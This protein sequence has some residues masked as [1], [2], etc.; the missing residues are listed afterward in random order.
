[1][2]QNLTATHA[3]EVHAHADVHAEENSTENRKFAM[4]LFLGSEVMFFTVLIAGVIYA[5]LTHGDEHSVLNIPLTSLNTFLL[6]TSSFTV[7]RSIAAI[8]QADRTKFLR[9]I[10]LTTI[11]G[12]IFL[13]IQVVEFSNLSK[14]GM[15]LSG[16]A[17][18]PRSIFGMAFF[19]L[20][21]FHGA[22]V[23]VGVIWSIR[24]FINAFNG[25]FTQTDHFPV[26]FFGLYWHF[27]DVVWIIIF[28]VVYLI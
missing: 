19:T 21:G 3:A 8:Q 16:A 28:T 17:N 13:A 9:S 7:V 27:V 2:A 4:W 10:I 15:T 5:R 1:M 6:L 25:K 23:L 18:D 14:E 12:T 11:L 24:L 22:H 20:T 26:E